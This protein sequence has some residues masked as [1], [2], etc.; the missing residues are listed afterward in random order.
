MNNTSS[1]TNKVFQSLL[2]KLESLPSKEN[3]SE[4][5]QKFYKDNQATVS[6]IQSAN[7][8]MNAY[9]EN[10]KIAKTLLFRINELALKIKS[11]HNKTQHVKSL[12]CTQNDFIENIAIIENRIKVNSDMSN[13]N[14][15]LRKAS[16]QWYYEQI[17]TDIHIL[18]TILN[19]LNIDF[20]IFNHA[21]IFNKSDNLNN[22]KISPKI[23]TD[24][25]Y[26]EDIQ[27]S[28]KYCV[29]GVCNVIKPYFPQQTQKFKKGRVKKRTHKNKKY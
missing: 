18:G 26:S 17:T 21:Q 27:K 23:E 22:C 25:S 4:T 28:Y 14:K 9:I 13:I 10:V 19:M 6:T 12:L 24:N 3:I 8:Y 16:P 2:D 29:D 11:I 1:G 20:N 5:I 15:L 7:F